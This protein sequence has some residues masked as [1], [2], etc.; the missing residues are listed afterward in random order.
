MM[1]L[2]INLVRQ[3]ILDT[4]LFA[5]N[6][7][8]VEIIGLGSLITSIT[9]GGKWLVNTPQIKLT[10]THGDTYGVVVA[11]EGIEK[12][13]DTCEF[14]PEKI[15]IAIVGA[16][17]LIG[18][19]ISK[20]LAKKGYPLILIEKTEEKVELI[21]NELKKINLEKYILITSTNLKDISNAEIVITATSYPGAILKPDY[22]YEL[23]SSL[24]Q[25]LSHTK[26]I[27]RCE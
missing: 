4:I 10:V 12:I 8:G 18:R 27:Y 6:K 26:D 5:Q 15:K 11:E 16:Y 25:S 23:S 20:F 14:T 13:L 17:G 7:L 21:K 9:N 22:L 1:A 2:P 19:E 24:G 3:R